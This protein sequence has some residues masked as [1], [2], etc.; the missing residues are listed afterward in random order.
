MFTVES[1][2]R[3]DIH[4]FIVS[5]HRALLWV[6]NAGGAHASTYYTCRLM[7]VHIVLKYFLEKFKIGSEVPT[8]ESLKIQIKEKK[9]VIIH[10]PTLNEMN[11]NVNKAILCT[12]LGCYHDI[13]YQVLKMGAYFGE[14]YIQFE[15]MTSIIQVLSSLPDW[16]TP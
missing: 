5:I 15:R 12:N 11:L 7:C 16:G 3:S 1:I 9:N 2:D 6:L 14:S 10:G 4:N 13:I 8:T